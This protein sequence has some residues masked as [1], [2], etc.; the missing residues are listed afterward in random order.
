M[1]KQQIKNTLRFI[2]QLYPGENPVPLH[3]PRFLGNEKK[4]LGECIDSTL[5]SYV[6]GF[7]ADFEEHVKRLTGAKNAVA[8]VS[9]TAALH[10]VLLA[11]G[12][13]PEDEVITQSLTF[14]ATAAGIRHSGAMPVFV[15]VDRETMGMSPESLKQWLGKNAVASGGKLVDAATGRRIAAV[16][17]MHTFGH[18]ARVDEIAK[19]CG[20][21]GV[22]LIED[23]AESI[24]SRYKGRHAGTFGKASILSFNGN[25]PV[26][27]GG[28]GM[29]L[30]DDDELAIRVRHISTTA[31]RKHRWEFYHDEVGYNLRMPNVNAAIGC[32]QMELFSRTF[33]NK[34]ETARRYSEFFAAERV[35]FFREPNDAISNY[36]LNAILLEDRAARDEFLG[37][38]NDFG[39]QTRPI[40]VLMHKLPPYEHCQRGELPVSEWFEE[41]TVN[42]PSSVRL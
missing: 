9:G 24:G 25:K 41:R 42:I 23:A 7:V 15:D 37:E 22:L 3:A 36:W 29:I 11:A 31:K 33:D 19:I 16:M 40:W 10:M 28:G 2:K 27:T 4:Y 38:S 18:P 35:E 5:V 14:A 1:N 12:I 26:T 6:G 20:D 21:F 13:G 30:T 39:V 17:P 34:R 8:I 32:A